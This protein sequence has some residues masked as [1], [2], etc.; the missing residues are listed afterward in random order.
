MAQGFG[1]TWWGN[2]WLRAL[3]HI[4]YAN[5]IPRGAIYARRGE[6][7]KMEVK[8]NVI[9]A[10]VNGSQRTP[11]KVSIS[12]PTFS[13]QQVDKLMEQLLLRPALISKLLNNELSPEILDIC[14]SIGMQVF[15][16][17]W[18]DLDMAC[19]CPDWA[20]PCKH[21]AAV[22]YMMSREIDNNPFLVFEIHGVN[23]KEELHK[24]GVGAEDD[25]LSE[26]PST[27]DML[28][29]L[30]AKEAKSVSVADFHRIDVSRLHDIAEPLAGITQPSPVF[31]S[32]GDFREIYRKEMLLI[33]KNVRRILD[34]KAELRLGAIT[35]ETEN[36]LKTDVFKW[37]ISEDLIVNAIY[38]GDYH[39]SHD[40]VEEDLLDALW[41]IDDDYLTDYDTS[42]EVLHQALTCALHLVANGAVTPKI[43][44]NSYDEYRVMW[45]PAT[46]DVETARVVKSL[47]EMM[48]LDL[49]TVYE[50]WKKKNKLLANR[51]EC[52]L[53]WLLGMI[54]SRMASKT[55]DDKI[56]ELFF[57]GLEN[58]FDGV[59][60]TSVP[61]S[62]R[63]WLDRFYIAQREYSPALMIAEDSGEFALDVSINIGDESM[64]L[65]E[66]MQD[67]RLAN[68]RMVALKELSQLSL[69]IHGLEQYIND[70]GEQP[71][72]F[73]RGEF[74]PFLLE[75]LPTIRLL[76]VRVLLP[77]SLKELVRP[78]ISVR[79]AKKETDGSS[80]L[81]LDD[82]L[83]FDWQVAIGDEFITPEE[84]LRLTQRASGLIRFKQQYIY[85]SETDILRLKKALTD[86]LKL[87]STQLLQAALTESYEGAPIE[88]TDEVRQLIKQLTEQQDIAVPQGITATLRPYQQRGYQWMYKNMRIGFGSIIA[89]DMGLGKTLQVITL[90]QQIKDEGLLKDKRALII[91][92]TGLVSNWQAEL[93]RFAPDLMVFVYHGQ[94]RLL[95]AFDADILLTTYGVLRS[96]VAQ[97]R[98]KQWRVVVIDEAQNIKNASTAQSK[99]VHSVP[100]D[101]HIAMSGTPV[102]NRL[103][104]FWS[105]M[106]FANSGY[107]GSIQTFKDKYAK[108]IQNEGDERVAEQFRRITAPFLLRRLKTDKSIITDLPDKVEQN[109]LAVLTESQAALYLET[110]Q[111]AM[112]TIEGIE[113]DDA[114]SLFKRQGLVLQMIL[115]LKQIC[116]HPALFLKNG[117]MKAEQSGKTELLL[118]LLESIVSSGQ[119]VLVFTQFREMGEMLQKIISERIG[120]TPLFLHGGCSI[121]QRQTMVERFQQNSRTDHIFLLS[122]KAAGTGLNL[123]AASHVI[124]YDLWWNP[125][126]EAQATDRAYRIGQHQN[127]LVHRFIT[128]NTFE[129]R[130]D[131]MIQD[132]RHLADMTVTAGEN[133]IGKLSNQELRELFE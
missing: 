86:T 121:K 7:I 12:V 5:R 79:L 118:T 67:K 41:R 106:D 10:R 44:R 37:G 18:D 63:S 11:Y 96:D 120:E 31:Y 3:T 91:V 90:L 116:N 72:H 59:G 108:P 87:S 131:R 101:T 38:I 60:E 127:V 15:P 69:Y 126:V 64:P 81:R 78:K 25:E 20:V 102:E 9:N 77:T 66:F 65:R 130:I 34:G 129:E 123:T 50:G 61:G 74:V 83:C 24:R 97:I 21:L 68:K 1:K 103:S 48:P 35:H 132:K 125:A 124:H 110:L 29:R 85:L 36:I 76:G 47:N 13:K 93:Q 89:D 26:V 117:D 57:H 113:D 107:L 62:I 16:S 2:E 17:R 49:L 28:V 19:S 32:H 8:G 114:K 27:K 6:V 88:L 80:Y 70:N 55:R 73:T 94:Q 105:I 122:L 111:H 104:E 84:F 45:L 112:Q 33:Q 75:S 52:L 14:R 128:K 39:F 71:I 53:A 98:K 100:A 58:R 40:F 119:K 46:I 92:P 115:A 43:V 54:I 82:M 109:E 23:L 4:D 51:A 56:K 22:I 99:A 133:W 95:K 30:S 42:I